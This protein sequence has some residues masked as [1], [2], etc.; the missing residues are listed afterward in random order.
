MSARDLVGQHAA[1]LQQ[2]G[3]AHLSPLCSE[4]HLEPVAG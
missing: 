1:R 4:E 2:A 3:I